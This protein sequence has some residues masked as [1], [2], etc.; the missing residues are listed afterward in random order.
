MV[1]A[2][3]W[4]AISLLLRNRS[5][6]TRSKS[7]SSRG[8]VDLRPQYQSLRRLRQGWLSGERTCLPPM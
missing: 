7:K 1:I 3:L 4:L 2:L 8:K 6:E 5:L